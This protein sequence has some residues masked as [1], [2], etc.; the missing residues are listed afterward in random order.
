MNESRIVITG[1]GAL[2]PNGIG[3]ESYFTALVDG[4]S[5]RVLAG[6]MSM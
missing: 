6:R 2:S 3:R 5:A 1:I 4:R